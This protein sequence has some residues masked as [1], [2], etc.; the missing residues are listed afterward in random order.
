MKW[1]CGEKSLARVNPSQTDEERAS[2]GCPIL[3]SKEK[4]GVF[5]FCLFL[6]IDK[7]QMFFALVGLF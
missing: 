7:L 3:T 2:S 1:L 5:F 4:A 6:N